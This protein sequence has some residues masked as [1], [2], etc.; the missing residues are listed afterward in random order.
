MAW[1]MIDG[2]RY[3]YH[4][5]QRNGRVSARYLGRG[6]EAEL[7]ALAM[8]RRK[9][10]VHRDREKAGQRAKELKGLD[11]RLGRLHAETVLLY[12][13]ALQRLGWRRHH[14]EWRVR[15]GR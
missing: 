13:A 14:R 2:R 10:E 8:E 12:A 6:R 3:F 9:A 15:A 4:H 5:V 1:S 7:A 11:D